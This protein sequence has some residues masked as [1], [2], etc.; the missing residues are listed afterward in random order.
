MNGRKQLAFSGACVAICACAFV[1]GFFLSDPTDWWSVAAGAVG[2][3]GGA[4]ML[5][6]YLLGPG[7]AKR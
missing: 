3:A 5:W 6:A 7:R 2:L 4:L 1:N